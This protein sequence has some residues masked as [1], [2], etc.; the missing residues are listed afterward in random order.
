VAYLLHARHVEPQK[1]PLLSNTRTQQ[2]NDG[3]MQPVSR[4]RLGKHVPTRNNIGNCVYY[5]VCATQQYSAVFSVRGPCR[6]DVRS[7]VVQC[8]VLWQMTDPSSRQR[9]RPTSTILKLSDSNKDLVLSPRCVLY[10]KT[11]RQT[12]HRS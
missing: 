9:E 1:Q 5:V 7:T 8:R 2:Y 12:D 11:D 4:Q 6:E 10:S 3:V